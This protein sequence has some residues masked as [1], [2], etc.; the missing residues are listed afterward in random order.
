MDATFNR[1]VAAGAKVDTP[2]I[3]SVLGWPLRENHWPVW[4]PVGPRAARWRRRSRGDEA[5][6]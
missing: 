2:L 6:F 3:R 4:P 5:P 1:A